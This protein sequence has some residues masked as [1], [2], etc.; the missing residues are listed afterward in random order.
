MIAEKANISPSRVLTSPR[1]RR[2][3]LDP[4]H[5]EAS[6]ACSRDAL[7]VYGFLQDACPFGITEAKSGPAWPFVDIDGRIGNAR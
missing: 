6:K 3:L 2:V 7:S 1:Y 4:L 5:R